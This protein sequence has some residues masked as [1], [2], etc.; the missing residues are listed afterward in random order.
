VPQGC[1]IGTICAPPGVGVVG[2]GGFLTGLLHWDNLST[3]WGRVSRGGVGGFVTGVLH[4]DNL[5]TPSGRGSRGG[6]VCHRGVTL[7]QFEPPIK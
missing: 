6:W 2:V 5:S 7:G 4:W 3:P 1:Y